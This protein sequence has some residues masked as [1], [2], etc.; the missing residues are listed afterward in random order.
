[1]AVALLLL[2][3]AAALPF[4]TSHGAEATAAGAGGRDVLRA[5]GWSECAPG[6]WT[7]MPE[8]SV[9][10]KDAEISGDFSLR[11]GSAL[12]WEKEGEWPLSAG[13]VLAFDLFSDNVNVSSDDYRIGK[14]RFPVAVTAVFG[15][16]SMDISWTRRVSAFFAGLFGGSHPAGIRLTYAFGNVAP[17]GSMYRPGDEE[18]TVFIL[19]GEEE[20]GKRVAFR[21]NLR[22]DFLAAYGREPRGPVTLLA[23]R[24]AR[25][26]SEKGTLRSAVRLSLPAP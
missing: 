10:T 23:V 5:A 8:R 20:R 13:P 21:R 19:A 18:E 12:L 2:I 1:M 25:P 16:D 6:W 17:V 22:E 15:R 14:A 4:A 24:A 9:R 7:G 11:P 26:S 3:A